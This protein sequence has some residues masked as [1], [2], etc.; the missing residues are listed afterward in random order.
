MTQTW[1]ITSD[2]RLFYHKK[3]VLLS[4]LWEPLLTD[5]SPTVEWRSDEVSFIRTGPE[6]KSQLMGTKLGFLRKIFEVQ[7]LRAGFLFLQVELEG[8]NMKLSHE[9]ISP[10]V[11]QDPH[12][13][14]CPIKS[15]ISTPTPKKKLKHVK[16]S[17]CFFW[18]KF[19]T[20][21]LVPCFQLAP[22][23]KTPPPKTIKCYGL[24]DLNH[25]T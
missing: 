6:T 8:T 20:K 23:P 12:H 1:N 7:T 10:N 22:S 9:C 25:W 19:S 17:S 18:N 21:A 24:R 14:S 2:W 15:Y 13:T 3:T 5:L 4:Q 16:P 11:Y